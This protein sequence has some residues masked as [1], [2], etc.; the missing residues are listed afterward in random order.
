MRIAVVTTY[1]PSV[2]QTFVLDQITGLLARGHEVDIYAL[3][4]EP[5]SAGVVSRPERDSLA[6][7]THY[8]PRTPRHRVGRA[9]GIPGLLRGA[10]RGRAGAALRTVRRSPVES[11]GVLYEGAPFLGR[12]PYD[13][14]LCHFGSNGERALRVRD[15]GMVDGPIVTA[16]HGAD[17]SR[18]VRLHGA[19]VYR[20]L[21]A[22]GDLFLPVSAFWGN[23]LEELGCPADRIAV[24][25]MGI[26]LSRFKFT[27][28]RMPTVDQ[29]VRVVS[30]ARLVEKKG[31]PYAIRAVAALR[32]G[33][34]DIALDIVGD[35][36]LRSSLDSLIAELG[37]S[38]AVRIIGARSR[39]EVARVMA[40][41]HLFAA[42]SVTARDGDMEGIPVALMEAMA[43]GVPVVATRH[44]GI[45]ELV[46]DKV[47]GLLVPERDTG[48][49]AAAFRWL[50]EHPERWMAMALAAHDA[51]ERNHNGE[52]LNDELVAILEGVGAR[53]SRDVGVGS[54]PRL[55][56][57]TVLGEEG[58]SA[59]SSGAPTA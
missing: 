47:S 4:P 42:P 17:M 59:S 37:M 39:D 11:I 41:A 30:V 24:H 15:A 52:R 5:N 29:P 26:D 28:P 10:W 32:L 35:G 1:F 38:N 2:S 23:R 54:R 56:P 7:R 36:P 50:V 57:S 33:G 53:G 8:Q 51:V 19:A 27:V 18:Y 3:A 20:D 9:L 49:L 12:G 16:F 34:F 43:S 22:R 25:H 31:L 21:F 45:P 55:V 14:I 48:A 58:R 13:A 40:G 46:E 6:E 44:S